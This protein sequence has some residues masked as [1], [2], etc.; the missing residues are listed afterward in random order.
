MIH[1]KKLPPEAREVKPQK[2][3]Y[4]KQLQDTLAQ[5]TYGKPPEG[6]RPGTREVPP[7]L[8]GSPGDS[9]VMATA[10]EVVAVGSVESV[11]LSGMHSWKS[12][13]SAWRSV[14]DTTW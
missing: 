11:V 9:F 8:P 7:R 12:A 10:S 3:D 5:I 2:I 14:R 1:V 4:A 13:I 6:S